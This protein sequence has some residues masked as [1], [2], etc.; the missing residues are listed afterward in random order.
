MKK[1]QARKEMDTAVEM[2]FTY[3]PYFENDEV[4]LNW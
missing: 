3:D 4:V 2:L 1:E